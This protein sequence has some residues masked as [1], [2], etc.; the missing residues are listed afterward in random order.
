MGNR[1]SPSQLEQ[2]K[3]I[4]TKYDDLSLGYYYTGSRTKFMPSEFSE[5][6][7]HDDRNISKIESQTNC[8]SYE[9]KRMKEI[10]WEK[11]HP[12]TGL[13]ALLVAIG[14]TN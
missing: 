7:E 13:A 14:F 1:Y 6:D 10:Y 4:R 11:S 3:N 9:V 5:W 8:T 2:E 12:N